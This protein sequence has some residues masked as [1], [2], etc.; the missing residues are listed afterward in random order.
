MP[1]AHGRRGPRPHRP[2]G[3]GAVPHVAGCG[4]RQ[5]GVA[6]G[7]EEHPTAVDRHARRAA[8]GARRA[9]H[10]RADRAARRD[11]SARLRAPRIEA[12][13]RRHRRRGNR[14]GHRPASGVARRCRPR[15][16]R[17]ARRPALCQ[18][19]GARAHR[20]VGRTMRRTAPHDRRPRR[21]RR[22]TAA[23]RSARPPG[24]I[25]RA[26][27]Q[28]DGPRGRSGRDPCHRSRTQLQRRPQDHGHLPRLGRQCAGD[29]WRMR[30]C[31]DRH[32]CRRRHRC[33]RASV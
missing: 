25:D 26:C 5:D 31:R 9:G 6:G 32:R 12:D 23:G 16:D 4:H 20:P 14:P 28:A 29:R 13:H 18:P 3:V 33:A 8:G 15:R 19:R 11:A 22:G 21:Y 2:A 7:S 27:G 24:R 10:P 17:P 1:A 30:G